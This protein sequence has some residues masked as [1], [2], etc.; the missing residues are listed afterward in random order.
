M[1]LTFKRKLQSSAVQVLLVRHLI[2]IFYLILFISIYIDFSRIREF[3]YHLAVDKFSA[4]LDLWSS[5]DFA[6]L[7]HQ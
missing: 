5:V 6:T 2:A 1:G 7:C 4:L 3:E